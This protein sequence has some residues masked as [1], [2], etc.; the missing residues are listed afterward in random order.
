MEREEKRSNGGEEKRREEKQCRKRASVRCRARV[1]IPISLAALD[2]AREQESLG[3]K[4]D[5][6]H[7]RAWAPAL[8][9]EVERG[10][11]GARKGGIVEQSGSGRLRRWSN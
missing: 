7:T 11:R 1:R 6:Y 4:A 9:A 10:G 3:K 2:C 8:V 5:S